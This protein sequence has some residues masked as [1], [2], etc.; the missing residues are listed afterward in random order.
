MPCSL[1][2]VR[3]V[4]QLLGADEPHV[5][6]C[7]KNRE[8]RTVCGFYS[9]FAAELPVLEPGGS[10]VLPGDG[11]VDGAGE[12]SV[13]G[14]VAGLVCGCNAAVDRPSID[15]ERR[16]AIYRGCVAG[17]VDCDGN[18]WTNQ[19]TDVARPDSKRELA[20]AAGE[21]AWTARSAYL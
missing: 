3:N 21:M 19:R 12:F 20:A 13:C 6:S 9:S 17:Y 15:A 7:A 14:C 1:V 18:F 10:V 2:H 16:S 8:G 4:G 11:A 5:C